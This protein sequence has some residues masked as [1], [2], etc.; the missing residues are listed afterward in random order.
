[1]KNLIAAF[2]LSATTA[3]AAVWNNEDGHYSLPPLPAAAAE[4]ARLDTD[5]REDQHPLGR[6][7]RAGDE[8]KV[9]LQTL[10][11][12]IEAALV[13]GFRPLWDGANDQQIDLL[14]P[15]LTSLTARQDG[16]VFLRLTGTGDAVRVGF[17][18]GKALPLYVDG[19][20][21][22]ADWRAELRAHAGAEFVQLV[23]DHAMITLTADA[24]RRDPIA[25][26]AASFAMINAVL[27]LEDDLSGLDGATPPDPPT[28]LRLHFIVDF[29]ASAA[30]RQNFYMYAT[31]GFIGM[32]PDNTGDLT[33]P[34]RLSREWAIWHEVGHIHQQNSWN[35]G[36]ATE[37][38][39][40]IWSLF[41]QES[42]GNPN[43]LREPEDWGQINP[44][45][46]TGL[47][48]GGRWAAGLPRR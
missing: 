34:D 31:D 37:I 40:N 45:R 38:T 44:C 28:P 8:I 7:V 1:M 43:R 47:Y 46:G 41:V 21:T 12:G 17:E 32:L 5:E 35:W 42:L 36:S 20:M 30:D 29:R 33:N 27:T 15:G 16:P 2:A 14:G 9:T 6:M 22:A 4:A 18:G 19:A 26:P 39:V 25:D 10:P 23:G 11:P 13:I 48:R 3:Q 24:Y